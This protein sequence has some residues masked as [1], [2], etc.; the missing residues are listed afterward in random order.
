MNTGTH[1]RAIWRRRWAVLA[2]AVVAALL[3]FGLRTAQDETF[4][5]QADVF[6]VP[7]PNTPGTS[8]EVERLTIY[9]AQLVTDPRVVADASRRFGQPLVVDD[10]KQL[11]DVTSPEDGQLTVVARQPTDVRA[12]ALANAVADALSAGAA[13]DQAEAQRRELAPLVAEIEEL[14]EQ[15]GELPPDDPARGA[16]ETRLEQTEQARVD[17]LSVSRARLD[18]VRRAQADDAVSSPRPARDALLA[19]LLVGIVGAELAALAAV[20]RRGIEGG[21]PVPVIESWSALPVF[22]VGPSRYGPDESGAAVR[23]L[24]ADEEPRPLYV[25]PLTPGPHTEVGIGHLLDA[26]VALGGRTTWVDLRADHSRPA[27]PR[28][29]EVV[30]PRGK[31]LER[32][33]QHRPSPTVVTADAWESSELLRLAELLPGT[34]VLLV[35]A[36]RARQPELVEALQVLGLADLPPE[37]VLVVE[38]SRP[39]VPG[40][41]RLAA[42]LPQRFQPPAPARPSGAVVA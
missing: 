18:V 38:G 25:A 42:L 23:F 29:A 33:A 6:L 41:P 12:A 40:A 27:V 37:A 8:N 9:Y 5:A 36:G 13:L 1:L 28:G 2:V 31:D 24:R 34:C 39:G 19:F 4:A 10:V 11:V 14:Q 32:T 21:D 26:L 7:A 3:V 17:A 30:R 20:R 15:L 35:D 16:L 22:R